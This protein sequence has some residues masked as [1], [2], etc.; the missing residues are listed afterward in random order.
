MNVKIM[1][2]KTCAPPFRNLLSFMIAAGVLSFYGSP[3]KVSVLLNQLNRNSR[4]YA[5]KHLPI[6]K[7][8][9]NWL[10]EIAYTLEFGDSSIAYDC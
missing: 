10:A 8:H 2:P 6:L 5:N 7:G 4:A 3:N 1:I 9:L